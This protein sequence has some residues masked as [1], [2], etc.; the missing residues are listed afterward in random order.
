MLLDVRYWSKQRS[1]S[2]IKKGMHRLI[3]ILKN[4]DGG[5]ASSE[6]VIVRK[7]KEQEQFN[8]DGRH[9]VDKNEGEE[10]AHILDGGLSAL[11]LGS[12]IV[13]TVQDEDLSSRGL[14][15]WWPFEDGGI[16]SKAESFAREKEETLRK[17]KEAEK[18]KK[19]HL[20]V[21][22]DLLSLSRSLSLSNESLLSPP[23]PSKVRTLKPPSKPPSSTTSS[24]L[25]EETEVAVLGEKK[26]G[27]VARSR[28]RAGVRLT[29]A[30]SVI[31]AKDD[32][33]ETTNTQDG[34]SDL[35]KDRVAD[36]SDH[37][38]PSLIQQ[39]VARLSFSP[40]SLDSTLFKSSPIDS[41]SQSLTTTTVEREEGG[42]RESSVLSTGEKKMK[43][44]SGSVISKTK[45][46]EFE[47][48][49]LF[50]PA[51]ALLRWGKNG[52]NGLRWRWLDAR[53]LSSLSHLTAASL[54][55]AA[56]TSVIGNKKR[57]SLA[58][59]Y[60]SSST[61]PDVPVPVPSYLS[62]YQCPFEI[63]KN[64]LAQLGRALQEEISCPAG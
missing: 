13:E 40:P 3:H 32:V 1:A 28:S 34:A 17:A 39:I 54:A 26:R 36:V 29:A 62:A 59:N 45:A 46:M 47:A 60:S 50:D 21:D 48:V 41:G 44:D 51:S 23:Q 25:K 49:T 7:R 9:G 58:T 64:R 27:F 14:V 16:V 8:G 22:S 33:D 38:F 52:G 37:R 56:A 2:E 5:D 61:L 55:S 6:P 15:G 12:S 11:T 35:R 20:M 19:A 18:K 43:A 30:D 57:K 53:Y 10:G 42:G 24:S 4:E 31:S 63:R